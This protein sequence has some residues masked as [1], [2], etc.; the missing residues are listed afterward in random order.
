MMTYVV[1]YDKDKTFVVLYEC[2]SL[3]AA[4]AMRK[5]YDNKRTEE[6]KVKKKILKGEV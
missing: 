2:N 4:L 3:R 5:H 6:I 1:G